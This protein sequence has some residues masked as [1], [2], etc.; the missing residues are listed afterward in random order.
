MLP[1][2]VHTPVLGSYNSALASAPVELAPPA[3]S[4]RPLGSKTAV[5]SKRGVLRL[6]V[7]VHRPVTGLY[8]SALAVAEFVRRVV[9]PPATR[10]IP[11]PS[12]VAVA[13]SRALFRLPVSVHP[14]NVGL[15]S[16]AVARAL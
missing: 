3:T 11:L 4:T 6:P 13:F 2:G 5:A 14:P 12:S 8:S 7:A 15:Y 16:S 10:T 1:V 9:W